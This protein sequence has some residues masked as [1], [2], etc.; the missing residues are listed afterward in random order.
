MMMGQ[1]P[2]GTSSR[3]A[4]ASMVPC[5]SHCWLRARVTCFCSAALTRVNS[6]NRTLVVSET[7]ARC[8][9]NCIR[10]SGLQYLL[11]E[12]NVAHRMDFPRGLGLHTGRPHGWRNVVNIEEQR[13]RHLDRNGGIVFVVTLRRK[14][15]S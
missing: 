3:D 5:R 15:V 9:T 13:A 14:A 6:G 11:L 10:T 8:A 4:N 1:Y 12:L 2:G 7:R